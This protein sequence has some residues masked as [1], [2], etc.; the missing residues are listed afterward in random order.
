MHADKQCIA[1]IAAQ[2]PN[3]Q[4]GQ[5]PMPRLATRPMGTLPKARHPP[6]TSYQPE[7]L[8]ARGPPRLQVLLSTYGVAASGG[9]QE[10]LADS[11]HVTGLVVTRCDVGPQGELTPL[12]AAGHPDSAASESAVPVAKP[13][14]KAAQ[15]ADL[16]AWRW[17]SEGEGVNGLRRIQN[18]TPPTQKT[19][20]AAKKNQGCVHKNTAGCTGSGVPKPRAFKPSRAREMLSRTE[21][22][23]P[24]WC[25]P[26][27]HVMRQACMAIQ[28]GGTGEPLVS[29]VV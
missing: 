3:H 23:A 17:Q 4:K 21:A 11:L 22:C 2:A 16:C 5:G 28:K 7:L 15:S 13:R 19:C 9:A 14:T 10:S 1:R 20:C 25:D 26:P 18:V 29:P 8:H 12:R 24:G 6:N 27:V